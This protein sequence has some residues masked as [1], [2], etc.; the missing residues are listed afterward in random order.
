MQDIW[1]NRTGRAPQGYDTQLCKWMSCIARYVRIYEWLN[2][3][4]E[5]QHVEKSCIYFPDICNKI[6]CDHSAFRR[7]PFVRR[8]A[9]RHAG[10]TGHKMAAIDNNMPEQDGEIWRLAYLALICRSFANCDFICEKLLVQSSGVPRTSRLD[11]CKSRDRLSPHYK[12][13]LERHSRQPCI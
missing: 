7:G 4:S 10:L 5:W 11:F 2:V 3:H 13:Q 1:R 8:T 6:L 9:T 12:Q